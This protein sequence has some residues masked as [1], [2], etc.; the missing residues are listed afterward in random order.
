M[1]AVQEF[2]TDEH[3]AASLRDGGDTGLLPTVESHV[4]LFH[5]QSC[6][7]R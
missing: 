1:L 4:D 2:A 3:G 5:D 7:T 6:P